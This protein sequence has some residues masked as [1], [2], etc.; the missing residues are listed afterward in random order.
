VIGDA[1]LVFMTSPSPCNTA[2][3]NDVTE[4]NFAGI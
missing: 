4:Q 1:A 3:I 2:P